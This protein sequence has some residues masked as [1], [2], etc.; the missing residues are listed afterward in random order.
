M[1]IH[2]LS[3]LHIE[4][5]PVVHRAPHEADVIILAGDIGEGTDGLEW[6]RK[7][8]PDNRPI[9]YVAGNHEFYSHDLSLISTLRKKAK[10]LNI[11]FLE[12]DVFEWNGV[13]FL[14]C[15]LWT[16][17]NNWSRSDVQLALTKM[18]DYKKISIS[19]WRSRSKN[20]AKAEYA[21]GKKFMRLE[22]PRL[23]PLITLLL[24]KESMKWLSCELG[25]PYTGNTV[26][27]THHAPAI[28]AVMGSDHANMVSL[29]GAY[30]TDLSDFLIKHKQVIDLW[31]HGHTHRPMDYYSGG[32]RIVTNA[33]GYP[34]SEAMSQCGR[35]K[36]PQEKEFN[37]K[38]MIDI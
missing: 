38:F 4:F 37:A 32:V 22:D 2:V 36:D 8:F 21:L 10:E 17:F 7:T 16:D 30:T 33:R 3:D 14:G 13:R 29:I 5:S 15:T 18:S 25:K 24:H 6:A 23:T 27:V 9:I 20:Q 31:V 19:E 11:Q 26:V 1:K 34:S 35:Q 12:N 28:G